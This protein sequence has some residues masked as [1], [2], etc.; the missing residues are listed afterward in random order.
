MNKENLNS[1]KKEQIAEADLNVEELMA[2]EGGVD[3]DEDNDW[4][5]LGCGLGTTSS[6]Y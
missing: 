1:E 2:V 4:C 3:E 5:G 6:N